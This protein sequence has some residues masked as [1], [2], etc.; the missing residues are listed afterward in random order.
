[1]IRRP[2][3]L[4]G[5]KWGKGKEA[6]E[7]GTIESFSTW[8]GKSRPSGAVKGL[9]VGRQLASSVNPAQS[10]R[11]AIPVSSMGRDSP[12]RPAG[13]ARRCP[14][15]QGAGGAAAHPW[16]RRQRRGH[17][18]AGRGAVRG[19]PGIALLAPQAA[20]NTWYPQRFL[21][22]LAQ[23]EPYLG[24]ALGVLGTLVDGIA[25][26]GLPMEK[27][28][29]IGFSQGACLSLEFSARHAR[30]YGGIVGLSG[31][32]IGPPGTPR[33]RTANL[34]GT[35]IYL[36]CSDRDAHIPLSSVEESAEILTAL[37]A[38]VTKS[39]F[40]GMGHTVNAEELRAARDLVRSVAVV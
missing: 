24:S 22:P 13:A 23:N 32:L 18:R 21:A 1:M 34:G 25:R 19:C 27:I 4:P 31:A 40:P 36:G 6:R 20:D 14:S 5:H 3:R 9:Q 11:E 39:I 2:G 12:R 35:P 33:D 15:R 29:L 17:L 7:E 16:T 8:G 26:G 10:C 30:R 28:I 37:G 38:T